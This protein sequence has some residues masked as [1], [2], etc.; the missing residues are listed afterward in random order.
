MNADDFRRAFFAYLA[1][2]I[3]CVQSTTGEQVS[4]WHEREVANMASEN[5]DYFRGRIMT[6]RECT[7][8]PRLRCALGDCRG[9]ERTASHTQDDPDCAGGVECSDWAQNGCANRAGVME[10][11]PLESFV[12]DAA[13]SL[14]LF[15]IRVDYSPLVPGDEVIIKLGTSLAK[16]PVY[17]N[18]YE[19]DLRT[20]CGI[21]PC[22]DCLQFADPSQVVVFDAELFPVET[23]DG[24]SC[25]TNLPDTYSDVVVG[26]YFIPKC[27]SDVRAAGGGCACVKLN[28][29]RTAAE[30]ARQDMKARGYRST[31]RG[32]IDVAPTE[33]YMAVDGGACIAPPRH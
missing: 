28:D 22:P 26:T 11:T 20:D 6:I 29:L 18:R 9:C 13:P 12:S 30:R 10:I 5:S 14:I 27:P 1:L 8:S 15:P 23:Q 21:D 2:A 31:D 19:I 32:F 33:M 17:L 3:G 25:I 7:P 16:S 24:V 4:P